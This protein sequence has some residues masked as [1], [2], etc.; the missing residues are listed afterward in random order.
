MLK[1]KLN[2][3]KEKKKKKTLLKERLLLEEKG[4][5]RLLNKTIEK[6]TQHFLP[7]DMV[8]MGPKQSKSKVNHPNF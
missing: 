4:V 6:Y 3:L 1:V 5:F 8:G 7:A 2:M